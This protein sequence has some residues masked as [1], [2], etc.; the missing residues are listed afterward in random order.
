MDYLGGP[1]VIPRVLKSGTGRQE[2]TR[3]TAACRLGGW[4]CWLEDGG[5]ARVPRKARAPEAGK[6][7]EVDSPLGPPKRRQLRQHLDF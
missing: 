7:K 5:S 2:R 6:S 4:R 1:S 3:E